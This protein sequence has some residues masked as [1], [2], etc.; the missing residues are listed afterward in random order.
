MNQESKKDKS[1]I[2]P[3][4]TRIILR[5]LNNI[6]HF[7]L[8][9]YVAVYV[10]TSTRGYRQKDAVLQNMTL[11]TDTFHQVF[12][13][14]IKQPRGFLLTSLDGI[15]SIKTKV[16]LFLIAKEFSELFIHKLAITLPKLLNS[17]VVYSGDYVH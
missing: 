10:F 4:I 12:L 8:M 5:L 2:I 3:E 16:V 7:V 17:I 11:K 1:V 6:C 13:Q 14:P 9:K 15:Q